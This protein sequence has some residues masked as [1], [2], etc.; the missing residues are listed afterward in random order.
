MTEMAQSTSRHGVQTVVRSYE[1]PWTVT[2]Q[3]LRDEGLS[4]MFRG[5]VPTTVRQMIGYFF[6]FGGY[7]LS[8][9]L[10]TPK[11]KSKDDLGPL[12]T[13]VC[14]GIGGMSFWVTTYPSDVIKSRVQ[15]GLSGK[16][17]SGSFISIL[18]KIIR[19]E[20]VKSLYR[21][22][23]LT[24]LRTIPA[25]GG[26]FLAFEFTKKYLEVVAGHCGVT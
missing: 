4:G 23:S 25:S 16:E 9:N 18:R 24:L 14:G 10:L 21:G 6:F 11:G 17:L 8:K 2:K 13:I 3:I 12:K 26:L 22:L 20:G 7:E 1:G 19:E 15:I 5:L